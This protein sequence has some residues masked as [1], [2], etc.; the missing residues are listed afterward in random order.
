M[1]LEEGFGGFVRFIIVGI[2]P[3]KWIAE[4]GELRRTGE[5]EGDIWVVVLMVGADMSSGCGSD[6]GCRLY[7]CMGLYRWFDGMIVFVLVVGMGMCL[8]T[9]L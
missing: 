5:W 8:W 6:G 4:V 9:R 1:K 3:R 7:G 2:V